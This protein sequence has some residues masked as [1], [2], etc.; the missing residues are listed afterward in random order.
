MVKNF[1]INNFHQMPTMTKN[2]YNKLFSHEYFQQQI[3]P[4]FGNLASSHS[5]CTKSNALEKSNK[6]HLKKLLAI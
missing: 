6:Q 4:N 3:F 5:F 2:F 1:I